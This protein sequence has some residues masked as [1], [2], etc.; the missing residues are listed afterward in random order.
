MRPFLKWPGNKYRIIE[1]IKGRLPVGKRLVEPFVGSGAVFLNTDYERYLLNDNNPDLITLYKIL[2]KEGEPFIQYCQTFF[3]PENN[4]SDKYYELR[5]LFN[6]TDDSRLKSALLIYLNRHGYNGLVRYNLQHE[7]NVPFGDYKRPYFPY[8]ELLFFLKK[9]GKAVF[10]CNDFLQT[11]AEARPGDVLYCD[12]PY[13]PLSTTSNFT[14]YSA[15]GFYLDRQK[16]LARMAEELSGR[17]I[18][19]LI[20][21]HDTEFTNRVYQ[22]AD[23]QRLQVQ[24]FISCDG[25]NRKKVG[26]ILALFAPWEKSYLGY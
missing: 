16:D 6:R 24:R 9:T 4:F 15:G 13:V 19:V 5:A 23:I 3:T 17:G 18:P 26:E 10:T 1:A 14:T 20:S 21:N 11:M 22:N 8:Q 12:P 7:L 2:K 25:K